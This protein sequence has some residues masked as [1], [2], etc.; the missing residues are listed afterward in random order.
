MQGDKHEDFGEKI[1]GARKDL[2]GSR[3]LQPDDLHEM[4]EREAEKFVKKENVWEKPEYMAM[5]E[6]GIPLGVAHGKERR[7]DKELRRSNKRG[8]RCMDGLLMRRISRCSIV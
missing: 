8:W 2:W 4:N 5:L 7:A 1:G 6:S 3:G